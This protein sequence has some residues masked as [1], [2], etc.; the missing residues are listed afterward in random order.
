MKSHVEIADIDSLAF[1]DRLGNMVETFGCSIL[2]RSLF[3]SYRG[4]LLDI[5][6]G[7]E[8]DSLVSLYRDDERFRYL[9]NRCLEL[10]NIDPDCLDGNGVL[11]KSLLFIHEESDPLLVRLNVIPIKD[12][13]HSPTD[14][15]SNEVADVAA[16]VLAATNSL[17]QAMN[18]LDSPRGKLLLQVLKARADAMKVAQ[19]SSTTKKPDGF[20]DWVKSARN[21]KQ[22]IKFG[23]N[24]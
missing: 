14:S 13:K 1:R 10:N 5:V 19:K 21:K 17:E 11:L 3:H 4:Q 7:S 24:P 23:E 18:C 15:D 8:S 22:P 12:T 9:C 20:D 16:A 2:G 6:R